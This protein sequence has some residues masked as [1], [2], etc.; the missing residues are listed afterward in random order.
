MYDNETVTVR[1][2]QTIIIT[3]VII[4]NSDL[5]FT[6]LTNNCDI[7][8][9]QIGTTSKSLNEEKLMLKNELL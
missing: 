1:A 9:E 3:S 4:N 5:T 2:C 7:I 8:L 6:Q